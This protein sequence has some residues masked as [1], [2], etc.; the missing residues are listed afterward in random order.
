[1]TD[2]RRGFITKAA[3]VSLAGCVRRIDPARSLAAA[4]PVDGNVTFALAGA[5]ELQRAGG[6]VVLRP[7]GAGPI[8]L[9]NSGAGFFALSATCPHERCDVTWVPEDRQAE[10][11]CHGS[12]FASDGTLLNPPARADL[13]S[14][15]VSG[16]AADGTVVVHLFAGDGVFKNPVRDGKFSFAIADYPALQAPG[17]AVLGRPD[18]FPGPLIVTR[19]DDGSIAAVNAICSHLGC[20]VLP[21]GA[22]LQCPCHASKFDL[23]GKF[24]TGPAGTKLFRYGVSSNGVIV[25]V[26]TEPIP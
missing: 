8:L 25:T 2:T 20:T 21:A 18:G 13:A 19:L 15:P 11:P 4:A 1:M 9:V 14:Y 24:L 23:G 17:G 10:C 6:A 5:P 12:R 7:A 16:P 3:V 26:S 22:V